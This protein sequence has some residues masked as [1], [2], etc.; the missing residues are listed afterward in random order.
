MLSNLERKYII[1]FK[2]NSLIISI[3]IF[4]NFINSFLN[5]FD[6]YAEESV[7]F[8]DSLKLSFIESIKEKLSLQ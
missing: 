7:I 3:L 6:P 8:I 2:N 4:S 5:S 1:Y